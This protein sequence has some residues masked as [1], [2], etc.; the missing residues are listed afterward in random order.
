LLVVE[1]LEL[2]MMFEAVTVGMA[3]AVVAL[4]AHLL[5]VLEITMV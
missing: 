5:L 3:A 2:T 1:V 4:Q